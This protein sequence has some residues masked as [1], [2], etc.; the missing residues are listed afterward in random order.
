MILN[1][2]KRKCE[3]KHAFPNIYV[4]KSRDGCEFQHAPRALPSAPSIIH[5]WCSN[6]GIKLPLVL[7]MFKLLFYI[8][9]ISKLNIILYAILDILS[10][11]TKRN[12]KY[13]LTLVS[14]E[15]ST[16]WWALESTPGYHLHSES[17]VKVLP[18]STIQDCYDSIL[19]ARRTSY[20]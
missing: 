8:H 2:T 20:R 11:I 17:A 6:I 1:T 10:Y 13:V 3:E 14:E 12:L 9:H 19:S 15:C 18:N 4:D 5:M 7:N 16:K